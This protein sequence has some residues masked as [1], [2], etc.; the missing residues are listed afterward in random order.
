VDET[1]ELG[2]GREA[3]AVEL[4]HASALRADPDVAVAVFEQTRHVVAGQAVTVGRKA[5]AV[6]TRNATPLGAD[7]QVAVAIL[8]QRADN[9]IGQSVCGAKGRELLPVVAAE[10][11]AIGAEPEMA[12]TV[13]QERPHPIVGQ[14]ICGRVRGE[15][16]QT[17]SPSSA[18]CV[19]AADRNRG[20][21]N[22]HANT[23]LGAE[24][25]IAGSDPWVRSTAS[26]R[27]R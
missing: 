4:R 20:N 12:V 11:G 22:S 15:A 26:I 16:V 13:L 10:T 27:S 7:P 8:E 9:T 6:V 24:V 19:S 25:A 2:E 21:S 5:C 1:I 14:S 17:E 23:P 18:R 3:M